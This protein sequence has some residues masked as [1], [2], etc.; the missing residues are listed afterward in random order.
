MRYFLWIWRIWG[1]SSESVSRSQFHFRTNGLRFPYC[2]PY[3]SKLSAS[4]CA[5]LLPYMPP[6]LR[7]LA[8]HSRILQVS[9]PCIA[10]WGFG[11]S[12]LS[13][14]ILWQH[15]NLIVLICKAF[16]GIWSFTEPKLY[17]RLHMIQLVR[18][19]ELG[20]EFRTKRCIQLLQY[21]I[22]SSLVHPWFS[23]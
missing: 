4:C 15:L 22:W 2:L 12:L 7:W 10:T 5:R 16:G 18:S 20:E 11:L 19:L 14:Q 1:I 8:P 6:E 23:E 17:C 13:I 9:W 21:T 3:S